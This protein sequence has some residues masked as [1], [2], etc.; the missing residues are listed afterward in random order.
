MDVYTFSTD[1][2]WRHSSIVAGSQKLFYCALRCSSNDA[3]SFGSKVILKM[4][5]LFIFFCFKHGSVYKCKRWL[6]ISDKKTLL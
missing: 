5:V 3:K 6:N 1:S 4:A 2:Y